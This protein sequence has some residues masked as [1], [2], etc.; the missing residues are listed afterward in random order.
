MAKSNWDYIIIGA[1]SAGC[2]LARGLGKSRRDPKILILEA[3]GSD[4]S[5][6]IKLPMWQVRAST[7]YDWG[8]RSQPDPSREGASEK[9]KEG[10]SWEGA[11]ASTE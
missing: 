10:G 6:L 2:A 8:Y 7:K 4:N 11:A 5:P 1:G 3:G 9:W